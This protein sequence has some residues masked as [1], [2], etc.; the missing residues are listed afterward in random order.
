[1]RVVVSLMSDSAVAD[2]LGPRGCDLGVADGDVSIAERGPARGVAE[3]HQIGRHIVVETV[4]ASRRAVVNSG[5]ERGR[6]GVEPL[7]EFGFDESGDATGGNAEGR[8]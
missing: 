7:C 6:R 1:M 8:G 4:D 5:Y 2:R 3:G